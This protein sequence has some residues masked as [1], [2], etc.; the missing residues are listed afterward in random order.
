MLAPLEALGIAPPFSRPR[1]CNDNPYAEALF[2]TGKYRPEYST[3]P[4]FQLGYR[5]SVGLAI[6]PLV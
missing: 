3:K 2:R 1:V 4:L 6:R 5:S